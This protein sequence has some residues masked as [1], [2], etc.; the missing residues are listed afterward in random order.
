MPI[1]VYN[2]SH[3]VRDPAERFWE[4]VD[5]N[6]PLD[7]LDGTRCWLWTGAVSANKGYEGYGSFGIPGFTVTAHR[8]AYE[9]LERALDPSEKLDHRSTC[10]KT[11]VN[12]E[13]LTPGSQK[14]NVENLS[15]LKRNNTTGFRGVY[16]NKGRGKPWYAKV[17]HN[18]KA[19]YGG[20]FDTAEEANVA[21][22]ALRNELFTN[23]DADRRQ[24]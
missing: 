22:I 8:F 6:G 11:C 16:R 7:P 18:G 15:G 10:S 3:V 14:Q 5:K 1:G 23:N 21:A 2:H 20:K 13:H 12:P 4:K 9:L 17:K 19:Y 24:S